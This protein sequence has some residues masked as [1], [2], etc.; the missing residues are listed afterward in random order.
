MSHKGSVWSSVDKVRKG[1]MN[2]RYQTIVNQD[3]PTN[4]HASLRGSLNKKDNADGNVVTGGSEQVNK[5]DI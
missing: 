2:H 4:D 5:V 3:Y 1:K